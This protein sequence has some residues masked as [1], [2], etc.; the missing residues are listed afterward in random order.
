MT[1][2]RILL[3]RSNVN[4]LPAPDSLMRPSQE[5]LQTQQSVL[6]R[7]AIETRQEKQEEE[8]LRASAGG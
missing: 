7:A 1:K 8:L 2:T 4:A 5:P 6:P 3:I